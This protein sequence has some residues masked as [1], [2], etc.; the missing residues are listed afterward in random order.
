MRDEELGMMENSE[1]LIPNPSLA[2]LLFF[3]LCI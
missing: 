2:P 1:L 3:L